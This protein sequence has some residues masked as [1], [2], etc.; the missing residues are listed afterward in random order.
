MIQF[1]CFDARPRTP[2]P[3]TSRVTGLQKTHQAMTKIEDAKA[4]STSVQMWGQHG[5]TDFKHVVIMAQH[6]RTTSDC[7]YMPLEEKN[8]K[9]GSQGALVAT[10]SLLLSLVSL[11]E[12]ALRRDRHMGHMAMEQD[13]RR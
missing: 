8:T 3:L 5:T 9:S 4:I 13:L 12:D 10:N 11:H 1:R 7:L 6:V 2:E